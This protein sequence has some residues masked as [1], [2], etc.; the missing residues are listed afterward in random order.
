MIVSPGDIFD[1]W[2]ILRMKVRLTDEVIEEFEEYEEEVGLLNR[3]MILGWVADLIEANS[4]M[5]MLEASIR[6]ELSDGNEKLSL[7]E[8]GRRALQIRDLNKKRIE[9]KN[10]INRYF[11]WTTEVKVNHASGG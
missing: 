1:K 11:G 10:A 8:V 3:P 6:Q 2:S 7:E 5:W 4:K 9:A